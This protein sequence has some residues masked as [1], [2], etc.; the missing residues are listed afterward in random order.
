M[1]AEWEGEPRTDLG[2][3]SVFIRF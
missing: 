2:S 1:I 3:A